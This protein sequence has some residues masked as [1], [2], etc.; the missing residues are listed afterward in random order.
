MRTDALTDMNQAMARFRPSLFQ[1]VVNAQ[2]QRP[3]MRPRTQR[4]FRLRQ[5]REPISASPVT[6]SRPWMN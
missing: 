5:V 6:F 2:E 3:R 1:S 4:I